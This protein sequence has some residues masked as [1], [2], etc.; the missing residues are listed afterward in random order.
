MKRITTLGIAIALVAS[1]SVQKTRGDCFGTAE[2]Y[3]CL[4]AGTPVNVQPHRCPGPNETTLTCQSMWITEDDAMCFRAPD[5]TDGW[6][7]K[8]P[9]DCGNSVYV[10]VQ[11]CD[12]ACNPTV[13]YHQ[14]PVKVVCTGGSMPDTTSTTCHIVMSPV[15]LHSYYCLAFL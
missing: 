12:A 11:T 5:A 8:V 15:K 3:V 14:G 1:A 13:T 6:R 2:N 4:P 7:I 10:T 9:T